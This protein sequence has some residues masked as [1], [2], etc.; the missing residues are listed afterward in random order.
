MTRQVAVVVECYSG[1]TY[2]DRPIAFLWNGR[3]H[4]IEKTIKRWR[5]PEGPGFR[6]VT[7]NGI[8]CDLVY[9]ERQDEWSLE[10]PHH[11]SKLLGT[12]TARAGEGTRASQPYEHERKEH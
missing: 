7:V 6:V 1:H 10:P 8:K 3:R 9:R 4:L 2:A 5:L 11:A 12:F